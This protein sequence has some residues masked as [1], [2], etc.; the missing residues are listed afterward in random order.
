MKRKR[1]EFEKR[2]SHRGIKSLFQFSSC[3]PTPPT[4]HSLILSLFHFQILLPIVFTPAAPSPQTK[5][6]DLRNTNK[7]YTLNQ[8][9]YF[10]ISSPR[11][12]GGDIPLVGKGGSGERV[13]VCYCQGKARQGRKEIDRHVHEKQKKCASGRIMG[14]DNK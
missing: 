2:Q 3:I 11:G 4:L 1:A 5:P 6:R 10:S 12:K 7:I 9:Y 14:N 8:L 13:G